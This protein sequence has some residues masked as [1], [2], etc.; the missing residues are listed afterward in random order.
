MTLVIDFY[1][2]DDNDNDKEPTIGAH[3]RV[4]LLIVDEL[5]ADEGVS[6]SV[7]L[8]FSRSLSVAITAIATTA[9]AAAAAEDGARNVEQ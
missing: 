5:H 6:F 1:V 8:S 2:N 9:A 3:T 7:S 4:L